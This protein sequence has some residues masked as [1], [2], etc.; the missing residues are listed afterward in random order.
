MG[1]DGSSLV[2]EQYSFYLEWIWLR[3]NWKRSCIFVSPTADF[4]LTGLFLSFIFLQFNSP[5]FP[6]SPCY[7]VYLGLL[8]NDLV[9]G[10]V[11]GHHWKAVAF[12]AFNGPFF[13]SP[14]AIKKQKTKRRK[15]GNNPKILSLMVLFLPRFH[16]F[17]GALGS[18]RFEFPKK[19]EQNGNPVAIR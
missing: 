6:V 16:H 18:S 17:V 19:N 7:L 2:V 10:N 4:S 11:V 3:L 1:L 9:P 12:A 14:A 8:F 5:S 13:L 15:R